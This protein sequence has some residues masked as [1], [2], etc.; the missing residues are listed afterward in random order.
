LRDSFLGTQILGRAPKPSISLVLLVAALRQALTRKIS[1]MRALRSPVFGNF[2]GE[3]FLYSIAYSGRI[4]SLGAA[5]ANLRHSDRLNSISPGDLLR[6]EITRNRNV[7]A[8]GQMVVSFYHPLIRISG[9]ALFCDRVPERF[10]GPYDIDPGGQ[11]DEVV[12]HG[13]LQSLESTPG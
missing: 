3:S 12:R 2:L 1:R 7:L 11:A 9:A 8:E 5:N 6:T 4:E 10:R 13:Y